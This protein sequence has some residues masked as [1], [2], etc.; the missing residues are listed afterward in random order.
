[1]EMAERV[2]RLC[3]EGL[4]AGQ[5][6]KVLEGLLANGIVPSVKCYSDVI[7]CQSALGQWEQALATLSQ[8]LSLS[9]TPYS[10]ALLAL[11]HSLA[12]TGKEQ[13][14]YQVLRVYFTHTRSVDLAV[15]WGVGMQVLAAAGE[16]ERLERIEGLPVLRYEG[17]GEEFSAVTATATETATLLEEQEEQ[18]RQQQQPFTPRS[19]SDS[20]SS[21]K[22]DESDQHAAQALPYTYSSDLLLL[23]SLLSIHIDRGNFDD[24]LHTAQFIVNER[25]D[26]HLYNEY[27]EQD[28][29]SRGSIVAGA[30]LSRADPAFFPL[31][32]GFFRL[33]RLIPVVEGRTKQHLSVLL[34]LLMSQAVR[35]G[36]PPLVSGFLVSAWAKANQEEGESPVGFEKEKKGF[37][38]LRRPKQMVQG[39][40]GTGAG[41]VEG[42]GGSEGEWVLLA[43]MEWEGRSGSEGSDGS[44]AEEINGGNN[45]RSSSSARRPRANVDPNSA[46]DVDP[47]SAD[48][49]NKNTS[50]KEDA[51]L[52]E[53]VDDIDSNTDPAFMHVPPRILTE[54]RSFLTLPPC[55]IES[56]RAVANSII[57]TAYSLGLTQAAADFFH[58]ANEARMFPD[59]FRVERDSLVLSLRLVSP[60]GAEVVV[61]GFFCT[62][63][64][65]SGPLLS[66]I[67][68]QTGL[69][70]LDE[71]GVTEGLRDPIPGF[72]DP[73]GGPRV[74][75][76][77]SLDP[78]FELL[79][80]LSELGRATGSGGG[81]LGVGGGGVR[82]VRI[83]IPGEDERVYEREGVRMGVRKAVKML[84][85]PGEVEEGEEAWGC[86]WRCGVDKMEAWGKWFREKN[87]AN[88]YTPNPKREI[89]D[90]RN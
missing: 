52:D 18:Q 43:S 79:E 4:L 66:L 87:E 7:H 89:L 35:C 17:I 46:A 23:S 55:P 53:L 13:E 73:M 50:S 24:A 6:V 42:M 57:D 69:D 78:D 51:D 1:M 88:F 5:A 2:V 14:T 29:L 75:V 15:F 25:L 49:A 68:R 3:R 83:E 27:M 84:E 59:L 67:L 21:D 62:W 8:A 70:S 28:S 19:F 90:V 32:I 40:G 47:G 58:A 63:C 72:R 36:A 30:V 80:N 34:L 76:G 65:Q 10:S 37:G 33:A 45:T 64:E 54:F 48:M 31:V 44:E 11:A 22:S 85:V 41:G 82:E 77:A 86:V 12:T 61:A 9:I 38:G 39:A 56:S 74:S 71:F 60:A 26:E 81:R 20:Y 16:E